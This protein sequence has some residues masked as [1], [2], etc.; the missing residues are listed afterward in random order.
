MKT[1]SF[2]AFLQRCITAWGLLLCLAAAPP[3]A[4]ELKVIT[5]G[6]QMWELLLA[7]LRAARRVIVME[8]YA[9][10]DDVSGRMVRDVLA[11]KVREGVQVRLIVETVANGLQPKSFFKGM[12][13]AGIDVRYNTDM[14]SWNAMSDINARDHRKIAVIDGQIGYV[15]GMNLSDHYQYKWLDTH[16]RVEGL[17]ASDLERVFY[18]SWHYLG[19]EGEPVFPDAAS[20]PRVEIVTGTRYYPTFL[21]R[22][23]QVLDDAHDYVWIQ[24]PYLCP[25]DTLLT[26]MKVAAVRGVDVRLLVPSITDISLLT[27]ANRNFFPELIAAGVRI[28]EYLPR[29]NHSKTLVCDDRQYWVGSVNLD[30]RSMLINSEA[31]AFIT[32]EAVARQQKG[33][34]L[35]LLEDA[36]EVS[37]EE[38]AAWSKWHRFMQRLPLIFKRQ[39]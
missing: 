31:A 16:L 33:V 12:E 22:Y 30:N 17:A 35:S 26:A 38:V 4:D 13:A 19:G 37:E 11:Q 39:L 24:T 20:D 34:F 27:T 8:F 2:S 18:A 36:H 7:D 15:G 25:P 1:Q 14:E 5:S 3:P 23:L 10:Y 9:F 21:N 29:F 6:E 32:D 28:Y